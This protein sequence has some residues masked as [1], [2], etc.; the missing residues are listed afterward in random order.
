MPANYSLQSIARLL[1]RLSWSVKAMT[2]GARSGKLQ[3]RTRSKRVLKSCSSHQVARQ[4]RC[5][6]M[7]SCSQQPVQRTIIIAKTARRTSK[8]KLGRLLGI[9]LCNRLDHLRTTMCLWTLLRKMTSEMRKRRRGEGV[10][11][12]SCRPHWVGSEMSYRGSSVNCLSAL[13]GNA[14][15]RKT[16]Q[17]ASCMPW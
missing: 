1:S 2:E 12:V 4:M 17:K 9:S 5:S 14:L 8:R 15:S 16:F 11:E 13:I 7:P 10:K 6:R 3:Q